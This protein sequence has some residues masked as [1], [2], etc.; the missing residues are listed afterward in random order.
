MTENGFVKAQ[1]DN[2][3][4]IDA[5]M[6]SAYF[7]SNHEFTS[8]EFKGCHYFVLAIVFRILLNLKIKFHMS[9]QNVNQEKEADLSNATFRFYWIRV[10]ENYKALFNF[11]FI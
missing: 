10:E 6:M 3:P 9:V 2:L 4:R 5:F 7:V 1:S 8:E 11:S